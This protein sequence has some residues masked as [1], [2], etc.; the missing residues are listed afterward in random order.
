MRTI[1]PTVLL[2]LLAVESARGQTPAEQQAIVHQFERA[3][4][5]Y[6]Q[7]FDCAGPSVPQPAEAIFTLPVS[8]VFRQRIAQAF[9]GRF[10][11]RTI[12]AADRFSEREVHVSVSEAF[13]LADSSELPGLLRTALPPL[14][15]G[16]EYRIVQFD[17]VLRDTERNV[18]VAVLRDAVRHASTASPSRRQ[19]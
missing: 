12:T 19:Q 10:D 7:Q 4:T 3:V 17:L 14:P 1:I 16:L 11:G 2:C 8:M 13:P 6:A 5:A 9:G 15:S 18:V